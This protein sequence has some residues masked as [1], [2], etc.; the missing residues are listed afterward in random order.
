MSIEKAIQDNKCISEE[1]LRQLH[2]ILRPFVLRR[3]KKDV[4]KQLPEKREV[5]VKC[6]LSR[7]QK[8]LYDEFI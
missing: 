6:D 4:E 7:R 1:V 5:I 2:D 3:L 8:Y